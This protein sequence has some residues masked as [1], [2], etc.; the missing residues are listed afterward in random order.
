MSEIILKVT[1]SKTVEEEVKEELKVKDPELETARAILKEHVN[2]SE[3]DSDN[4]EG[5]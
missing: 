1:G 3:D 4:S 5:S 2:G